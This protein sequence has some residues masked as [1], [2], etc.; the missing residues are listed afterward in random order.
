MA[1]CAYGFT[2][3]ER[4]LG[5]RKCANKKNRVGVPAQLGESISI[6]NVIADWLVVGE[7]AVPS[8]PATPR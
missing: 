7:G 6:V 8:A 5:V 4:E 3:S 1:V 2:F